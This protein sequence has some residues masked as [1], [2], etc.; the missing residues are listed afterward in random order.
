MR[1]QARVILVGQARTVGSV[2]FEERGARMIEAKLERAEDLQ[3]MAKRGIVLV[4]AEGKAS[5]A[6]TV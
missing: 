1:D 2:V 6:A 5:E 3:K 4:K